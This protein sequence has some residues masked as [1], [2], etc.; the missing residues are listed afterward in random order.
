MKVKF[1]ST[2]KII[3]TESVPQ[4]S[5]LKLLEGESWT[6]RFTDNPERSEETTT[7]HILGPRGTCLVSSVPSEQR[8]LGAARGRT[9]PVSACA[10]RWMA[11]AR[12]TDTTESRGKTNSST[13]SNLPGGLGRTN[14]GAVWDRTLLVSCCTQ[15]WADLTTLSTQIWLKENRSTGVLTHRLTGG[16][17]YY[18]RQQNKSTSET[19]W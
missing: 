17:S 2:L 15:N 9:L 5:L 14:P 10:Q 16:L 13:P 8:N 7:S 4:L 11:V 12:S 6:L 1:T 19:T 18:Q 3:N